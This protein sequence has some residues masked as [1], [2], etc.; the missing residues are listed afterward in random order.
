MSNDKDID[1]M[2]LAIGEAKKAA[3]KG[4]VPVGAVVVYNDKV[5]ARGH[6]VKESESDPAGHAEIVAI[7]KAASEL[8][9]WRLAGATLYVTLEPC[10]MCMGAILEARIDRLLFATYDEKA[11]ACG[12]VIDV[13]NDKM[14]ARSVRVESA[15]LEDESKAVLSD[16][17]KGLRK[18]KNKTGAL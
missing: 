11:G 15:I 13:S 12:S 16:F 10:L 7:R 5:I 18:G 6:N 3:H 8:K 14:L 4:E 17:F 1:F 9:S 2:R